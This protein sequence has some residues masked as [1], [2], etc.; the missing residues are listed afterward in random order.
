MAAAAVD[1]AYLAATYSLAESTLNTLLH[2]PTV[3]LVQT[4]LQQLEPK[5]R[6]HERLK[7][8]K[9]RSEVELESAV[10]N[11][12]SRARSLKSSVDKG[13][14]EVEELRKQLGEQGQPQFSSTTP[15]TD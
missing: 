13:L 15:F 1:A 14:K 4:L 6:E 12:E 11:G 2:A 3:D 10:R 5:A 8:E 9:L 7:A